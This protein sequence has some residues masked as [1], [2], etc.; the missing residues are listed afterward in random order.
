MLKEI[1]ENEQIPNSTQRKRRSLE[2]VQLEE[3]VGFLER[4]IERQHSEISVLSEQ[5]SR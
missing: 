2:G 3:A 1:F 5:L 4:K